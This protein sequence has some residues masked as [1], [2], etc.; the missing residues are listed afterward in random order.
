VTPEKEARR[1]G[2]YGMRSNL[3]SPGP[4]GKDTGTVRDISHPVLTATPLHFWRS[5]MSDE[6][7]FLRAILDHPADDAPR[8]VYA[9]WLDERGDRVS[10][11]KARFL[12]TTAQAV[13]ARPRDRQVLE[14]RL[15]W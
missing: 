9:D 4:R 12:R 14:R 1:V 6:D 15:I 11:R 5:I 3:R 2:Y 13:R 10:V 8:L 7:A